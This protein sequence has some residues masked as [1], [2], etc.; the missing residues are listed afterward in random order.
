M[1]PAACT[2]TL[3]EEKTSALRK[4][5]EEYLARVFLTAISELC[6]ALISCR[7]RVCFV[8]HVRS[9]PR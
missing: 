8:P 3:N 1:R 4:M 9:I 5:G 2:R 7:S 6:L